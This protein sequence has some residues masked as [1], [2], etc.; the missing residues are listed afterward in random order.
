MMQITGEHGADLDGDDHLW[1]MKQ[2][3]THQRHETLTGPCEDDCEV[4]APFIGV[5]P[6][7]SGKL[8]GSP[9]DFG[10]PSKAEVDAYNMTLAALMRAGFDWSTH[11]SIVNQACNNDRN[12][13][14]NGQTFE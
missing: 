4:T 9:I 13:Y 2:R 7:E 5:C 12:P 8:D 11:A 6:D 14:A 3:D 1:L 10:G